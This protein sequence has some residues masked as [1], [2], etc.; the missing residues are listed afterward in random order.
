MIS[1]CSKDLWEDTYQFNQCPNHILNIILFELETFQLLHHFRFCDL[2]TSLCHRVQDGVTTV[3]GLSPDSSA[4]STLKPPADVLWPLQVLCTAERI[5]TEC[6]EQKRVTV[7]LQVLEEDERVR[8]RAHK[9]PAA[10]EITEVC[11]S[12]KLKHMRDV[13]WAAAVVSVCYPKKMV[14][15]IWEE[16]QVSVQRSEDGSTQRGHVSHMKFSLQYLT[17][18]FWSSEWFLWRLLHIWTVLHV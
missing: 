7:R 18:S 13:L 1:L 8:R 3:W 6:R 10:L 5:H 14:P 2:K 12:A 9:E 15:M 4:G 17:F 16:G 11:C